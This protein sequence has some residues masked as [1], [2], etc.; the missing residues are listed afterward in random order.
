M[1][2]DGELASILISHLQ[3]NWR[4]GRDQLV[5]QDNAMRYH[6]DSTLVRLISCLIQQAG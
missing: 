1:C 5:L 3:V 2:G 6:S 4:A